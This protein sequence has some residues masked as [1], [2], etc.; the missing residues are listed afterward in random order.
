MRNGCLPLRPH[1]T[2]KSSDLWAFV[3][4]ALGAFHRRLSGLVTWSTILRF[5]RCSIGSTCSTS[6][7]HG[8]SLDQH[9]LLQAS[10]SVRQA[11]LN[12]LLI[13][14]QAA[15]FAYCFCK[16]PS[17]SDGKPQTLLF[18]RVEAR[19]SFKSCTCVCS[20]RYLAARTSFS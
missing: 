4:L 15:L 6:A 10:R 20:A 1:M 2:T 16:R 3:F 18:Q 19:S 11:V 17:C 12:R 5:Q 7:L 14:G 8:V 9:A 13:S